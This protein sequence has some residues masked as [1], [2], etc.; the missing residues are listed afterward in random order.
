[1]PLL[2]KQVFMV[3]NKR[4]TRGKNRFLKASKAHNR[5]QP[6]VNS[7]DCATGKPRCFQP[8]LAFHIGNRVAIPVGR[9]SLR[10]HL[11]TIPAITKQPCPIAKHHRKASRSSKSGQIGKPFITSRHFFALIHIFAANNPTIKSGRS[12]C[13]A[14]RF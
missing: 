1:M 8:I 3:T 2:I 6:A 12:H 5:D 9:I 4:S 14:K 13:A 7:D 10:G 11:Q